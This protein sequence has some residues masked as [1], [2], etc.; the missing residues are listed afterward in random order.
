MKKLP[1]VLQPICTDEWA[2]GLRFDAVMP[3]ESVD[4]TGRS[5]SLHPS[6]PAL[7]EGKLRSCAG[8]LGE[9]PLRVWINSQHFYE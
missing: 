3:A 5:S 6:A 7:L 4:V 8:G 2:R 9:V 1:L